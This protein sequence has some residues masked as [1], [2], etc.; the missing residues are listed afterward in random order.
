MLFLILLIISFQLRRDYCGL[1]IHPYAIT[2][3][4]IKMV[5]SVDLRALVVSHVVTMCNLLLL[6]LRGSHMLHTLIVVIQVHQSCGRRLLSLST[7]ARCTA[8]LLLIQF[9]CS[10]C[11]IHE[12]A[13]L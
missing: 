7:H 11:V 12:V 6:V 9:I 3:K 5:Q 8:Q 2:I 10:V 1:P 13:L 4:R